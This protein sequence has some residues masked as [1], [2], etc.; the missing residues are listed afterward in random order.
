MKAVP[1]RDDWKSHQ[2]RRFYRT[3]FKFELPVLG[4]LPGGVVAHLIT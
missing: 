2:H 1:R 4:G 3:V